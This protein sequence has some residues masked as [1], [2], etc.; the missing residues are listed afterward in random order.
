M[1]KLRIT[2]RQFT[3]ARGVRAHEAAAF[4]SA[5]AKKYGTN[6]R[7]TVDQWIPAWDKFWATPVR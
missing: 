5:A 7:L 6:H 2:A 3:L 1:S 4:L